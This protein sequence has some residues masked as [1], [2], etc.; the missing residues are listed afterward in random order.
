MSDHLN[1]DVYKLQLLKDYLQGLFIII[2]KDVFK[3]TIDVESGL[4]GL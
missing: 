1:E 4:N 3:I 2:S